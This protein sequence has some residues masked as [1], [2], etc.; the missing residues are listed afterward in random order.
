V[1]VVAPHPDDEVLGAGGL[2]QAAGRWGATVE[3]VAVTDG[4]AAPVAGVSGAAGRRALGARR[5]EERAAAL[6]RLTG[7]SEGR[8]SAVHRLG[9]PDGAV[10][11]G[12]EALRVDL[13]GRLGPEAC[14]VAPWSGDGHPDHEAAGRA[15][16]DA[17]A[18]T[19]ATLWAYPV[20]TW[21]WAR[22][23]DPSV[24]WDR[25]RRLEV[26]AHDLARKRS[27]LEA[28]VSQIDTAPAGGAPVLPVAF[29]AHFLRPF[30]VFVV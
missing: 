17:A 15:A 16:E 21:H 2:M 6:E 30:E 20:W 27:A 28:F 19:G 29:L 9:L 26:G 8:P 14:C 11:G 3:V 12:E 5:V 24:P 23:A 7:T 10:A 1:V 18:A 13:A 25:A 22:P 4:E